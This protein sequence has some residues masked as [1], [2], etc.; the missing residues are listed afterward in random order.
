MKTCINALNP[1]G[2]LCRICTGPARRRTSSKQSAV[3]TAGNDFQK[4]GM[5]TFASGMICSR[6]ASALAQALRMKTKS[7][8]QRQARPAE[9]LCERRSAS[10]LRT[11]KRR[12][13]A[14]FSLA[15]QSLALREGTVNIQMD[16]IP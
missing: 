8:G 15:E 6:W 16:H 14:S 13:N 10:A 7:T 4:T 1:L 3:K 11:M 9:A 5:S 12:F 2:Q